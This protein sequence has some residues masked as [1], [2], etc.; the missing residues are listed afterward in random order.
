MKCKAREMKKYICSVSWS[1]KLSEARE[2][3]EIFPFSFFAKLSRTLPR[4]FY[5]SV[6]NER[7]NVSLNEPCCMTLNGKFEATLI[8]TGGNGSYIQI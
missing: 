6:I 5:F 3:R 2:N 4:K 7:K 1:P 8:I